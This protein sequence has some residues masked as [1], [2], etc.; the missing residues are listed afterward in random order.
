VTTSVGKH[1]PPAL[2]PEI[3]ALCEQRMSQFDKCYT[4]LV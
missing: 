1:D 3:E 4:F 2:K